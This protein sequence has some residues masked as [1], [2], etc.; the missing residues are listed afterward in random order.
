VPLPPAAIKPSALKT[1]S[2]GIGVPTPFTQA[3]TADLLSRYQLALAADP[4]YATTPAARAIVAQLR[5]HYGKI[6]PQDT[7][8]RNALQQDL[9]TA[10]LWDQYFAV[11]ELIA[12]HQRELVPGGDVEEA[13]RIRRGIRMLYI[14]A[15]DK[16]YIYDQLVANG[17]WDPYF[18]GTAGMTP[19]Q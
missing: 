9:A 4:A 5:D 3:P 6:L 16:Q 15:A 8:A 11:D 7:T 14:N 13:R 18:K 10:G 17:L 2:K 1:P 12:Q 19:P